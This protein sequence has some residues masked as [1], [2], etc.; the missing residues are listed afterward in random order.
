MQYTIKSSAVSAARQM[1]SFGLCSSNTTPTLLEIH[2]KLLFYRKRYMVE[3]LKHS[4]HKI[5]CISH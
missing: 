4:V 5:K 1:L 3:T 2:V